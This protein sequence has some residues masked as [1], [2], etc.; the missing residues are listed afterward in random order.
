MAAFQQY[1][2]LS[3]RMYC[4]RTAFDPQ[5]SQCSPGV[6][7]LLDALEAASAEGLTRAEFLGGDEEYKLELADG[8]D[9]LY[10]AFGLATSLKGQAAA[11]AQ[12]RTLEL[13]LRL[14]S[15]ARIRSGY[16]A[17]RSLLTR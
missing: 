4:Y 5:F 10:D 1:F 8:P 9:P 15:S 12:Q 6:L 3:G 2:A 16:R 7:T 14:K 13:R 17:A 11:S